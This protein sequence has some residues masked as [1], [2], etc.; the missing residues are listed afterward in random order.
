MTPNLTQSRIKKLV[1]TTLQ[2]S[3]VYRCSS[4]LSL[5]FLPP[6]I[7]PDGIDRDLN[8]IA[9]S[10]LQGDN[11]AQNNHAGYRI[12]RELLYGRVNGLAQL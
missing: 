3:I 1:I 12:N 6:L 4:Q 7:Y 10:L 5:L 11:Y 2:V 9:R 8:A